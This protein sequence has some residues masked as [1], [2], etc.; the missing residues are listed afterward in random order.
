MKEKSATEYLKQFKDKTVI[1]CGDCNTAHFPIDLA[2]PK[3]TG[4][5]GLRILQ[6]LNKKN[7]PKIRGK[8]FFQALSGKKGKRH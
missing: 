6:N 3:E 8:Q 7:T 1:I 4:N 2:R 5:A